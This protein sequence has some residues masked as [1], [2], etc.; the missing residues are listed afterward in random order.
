MLAYLRARAIPG[1]EVVGSDSYQRTVEIEGVTGS[2]RIEH[3]PRHNS[4]RVTIR[5]SNVR[6]LPAIVTDLP[7][8]TWDSDTGGTLGTPPDTVGFEATLGPDGT[9]DVQILAC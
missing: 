2:V 9:Y 8:V 7:T 3:L 5:F 6:A 4:L 1:M